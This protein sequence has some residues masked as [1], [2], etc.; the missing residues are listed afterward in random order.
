L[1]AKYVECYLKANKEKLSLTKD[2]RAQVLNLE[3]PIESNEIERVVRKYKAT[4][5]LLKKIPTRIE[6]LKNQIDTLVYK[7]YCVTKEE[8]ALIEKNL[9]SFG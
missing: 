6:H 5:H 1:V 4:Q 2:V 9:A 3:I 8:S 7:L